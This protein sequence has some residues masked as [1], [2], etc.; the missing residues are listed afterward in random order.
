MSD[1]INGDQDKNIDQKEES[2]KSDNQDAKKIIDSKNNNNKPHKNLEKESQKEIKSHEIKNNI[3]KQMDNKNTVKQ[4]VKKTKKSNSLIVS[5]ALILGVA[6]SAIAVYS[7]YNQ[8]LENKKLQ[9]SLS[10]NKNQVALLVSSSSKSND[11][12]SI[13]EKQVQTKLQGLE[14]QLQVLTKKNYALSEQLKQVKSDYL[15][16]Q[17]DLYK[18]LMLVEINTA[19]TY[20]TIASNYLKLYADGT[21]AI[22]LIKA[23][24]Q[25]LLN[26][27]QRAKPALLMVRKARFAVENAASLNNYQEDMTSLSELINLSE[28]LKLKLPG[29]NQTKPEAPRTNRWYSPLA[30]SWEKIT[31]LVKVQPLDPKN[32]I[33][34]NT[35]SRFEL[36]VSLKLQL[37]QAKWALQ[38][39][40]EVTFNQSMAQVI[41]QVKSYYQDNINTQKWLEIAKSIRFDQGLN[42]QKSLNDAIWSVTQ[43]ENQVLKSD[44]KMTEND[45]NTTQGASS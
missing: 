7:L 32:K 13:A 11:E 4:E 10:E 19:H 34:L 35:N 29:V 5:L 28:Q 40:D 14:N 2:K 15:L 37:E 39:R 3:N 12:I 38:R 23:A 44:D 33:L 21:Q 1:K 42:Y 24:E 30:T 17:A 6:G 20:L 8:N 18:Q 16:P 26:A 22:G 25:S 9:Q 31:S 45:E 43:L 27:D 36:A 41:N